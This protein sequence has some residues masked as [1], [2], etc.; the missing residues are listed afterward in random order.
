MLHFF[1]HR[2]RMKLRSLP[3]PASWLEIIDRNAPVTAALSE[4]DRAELFGHVHVLL[5]EKRIEGCGGLPMTDEI[6]V[7]IAAQAS[8]LLLHR[9]TDYFPTLRSVLVYPDSYIAP[10]S[11]EQKDGTVIEGHEV[12]EGESWHEGALALSW[13]DVMNGAADPH[14]GNNLVLHE[15]AHQLDSETGDED[16]MP[17]LASA[18]RRETWRRVL[19]AEFEALRHAV[20][21]MRP[22]LLDEYGAESPAEFFAVATECFF[23][24]PCE[25]KREHP[26]LYEQLALFYTL[27]PANWDS[28]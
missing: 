9:E 18:A 12:R 14:D 19:G 11:E 16:G 23:E 4:A 5:A 21:D 3:V 26:E 13:V 1:K 8:L 27:D 22:T 25:L 28:S 6:R 2:R 7:T 15:F 10:L 17:W 24:L 20:E